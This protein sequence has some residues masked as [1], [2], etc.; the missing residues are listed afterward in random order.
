MFEA[1]TFA[2]H[3][4]NVDVMCQAIQQNA[5]E[6]FGT[7]DLCPFIEGQVRGYDDGSAFVTLRDH[8][9]EQFR[10]GF[11]EGYKAQLINDQQVLA[12]QLF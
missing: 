8:F 2:V 3:L 7:K 4:E 1:V 11:A 10:A 9:K 6:P 5:C 12:G